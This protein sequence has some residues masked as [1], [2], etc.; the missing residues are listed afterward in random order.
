MDELSDSPGSHTE[1]G[2][3]LGFKPR[4][5]ALLVGSLSIRWYQKWA[6]AKVSWEKQPDILETG[7][8]W[9]GDA[10]GILARNFLASAGW[11]SRGVP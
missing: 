8:P 10:G 2:A 3:K 9:V 5:A 7:V 6:A 1:L 11:T 4:S